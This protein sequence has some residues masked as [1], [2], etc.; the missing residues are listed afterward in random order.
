MLQGELRQGVLAAGK[1][2]AC[3]AVTKLTKPCTRIA[4]RLCA[5]PVSGV[6]GARYLETNLSA[7]VAVQHVQRCADSPSDGASTALSRF[8]VIIPL[9][10]GDDSWT[11]R[12]WGRTAL[13]LKL[14]NNANAQTRNEHG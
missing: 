7:T 6:E 4:L 3:H 1:G 13:T 10:G 5:L 14:N 8:N 12:R 2:N 11:S 9:I